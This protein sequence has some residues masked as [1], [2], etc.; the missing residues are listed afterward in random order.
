MKKIKSIVIKLI[1]FTV[2]FFTYQYISLYPALTND[3]NY[4]KY[5]ITKY[6]DVKIKY[7]NIENNNIKTIFKDNGVDKPLVIYF[8]G[9]Y[10]LI[11]MNVKLLNNLF[12]DKASYLM[13]EYNGYGNSEG[14]PSLNNTNNALSFVLNKYNLNKRKL[15]V[16]GRSIGSA[17]AIDYVSK[18]SKKVEK[19]VLISSF[20]SPVNII[21]NDKKVY[22]I[23]DKLMFFN[24]NLKNKVDNIKN[25]DIE[26]LL[27]HGK[28]DN[29]FP[30]NLVN[31]IQ[32]IF[33]N[34]KI[35]SHK[36]IVEGNHNT[37]NLYNKDLLN[38]ILN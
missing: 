33:K 11:D 35:I 20:I 32:E 4:E 27:M 16:I 30:V 5:K 14:F 15:T 28:K 10:E 36:L 24:Y 37:I 29:M 25:K 3:I 22:D 23:L 1:I 31:D 6:Q 7:F 38:F 13:V 18:N 8:H 26:V 21:S 34:K 17:H 2:I 19:L 12:N 9:N